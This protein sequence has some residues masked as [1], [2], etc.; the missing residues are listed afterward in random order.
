MNKNC[1]A[2]KEKVAY[3]YFDVHIWHMSEKNSIGDVFWFFWAPLSQKEISE[4]TSTI[5]AMKILLWEAEF[6]SK[7]LIS[8]LKIKKKTILDYKSSL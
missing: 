4:Q 5:C 8:C 3:Y 6:Y 2:L 1:T 7:R